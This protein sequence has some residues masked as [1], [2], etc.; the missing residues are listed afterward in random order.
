MGKLSV[1]GCVQGQRMQSAMM[2]CTKCFCPP[3]DNSSSAGQSFLG[4]TSFS[5]GDLLRT[6]EPPVSLSL[7]TLDG[8]NEAGELKVSRLQMEGETSADH[9]SAALCERLHGSFH[10]R[11]NS[12]MMRA[13]LCAQVCKVYR[14]QTEDQRWLLVR[15]Q[16]SETP[17]SFSFPKQ[18]LSALIRCHLDRVQEVKELGDLSPRWDDLRR[19]VVG[20]C[21]LL[22]GCYQ[23]TLSELHKLSASS[24]FK[25]SGSKADKQL[26]FVPTNLHAQRMEVTGPDSTG[27]WYEVITFGAPADHHQAFKHGGL[28]KL[29]S[30]HTAP[31]VSYSRDESGRARALLGRVAALQPLLF[32]LA[33]QLLAVALQRSAARLQGALQELREQTQLFV[34]ALKD[35]L[36]KSALLEIHG[37][38][39]SN[40]NG[41]GLGCDD[42]P[43]NQDE[44]QGEE[45]DEEEWDR[46]WVN[47][48]MSLNCIVA[49]VD[50]LQGREDHPQEV[51][52]SGLEVTSS[53][54][55]VTSSGLEVTS[56][57][58]EETNG[59]SSPRPP[60]SS[61]SPSSSS[62]SSSSPSWQ[63]Q[64]LPL[65]V[66]L[67]DC[68]REAADK[69]R[70]AM[71]FVVLQGAAASTVGRGPAHLVQRRHAVFSQALCAVVCGFLLKLSGRLVEDPDF[72]LQLLSVGLLVQFEGL[73]STYGDEVG[74]L[75][76][77]DVGVADL[78]SVS[79]SVTEATGERPE[80]LLPTL[81]GAWGR[82][83]VEVPLPSETFGPLPQEVRAGGLI[84]VH[85]VLF[86]VGINQQQ[87]LAERF[88]DSSLQEAVNQRGAERLRAYCGALS[89]A[90]P[91]AAALQ[92][93][94]PLLTA[95]ERR[96][97][98]RKRK[99]VS[100]L[101]SAATVC[102]E[103]NGVRLTSCKSAKDRTAMSVTLEQCVLL[104]ER[105]T[106]DPQHF[107]LA[108]D[109]MR[110]TRQLFRGTFSLCWFWRPL[111][112]TEGRLQ[113][114]QRAEECGQQEVRL[115]R[116]SAAHVPQTVPSSRRE[117]RMN[118][119]DSL[120]R[121]FF[122]IRRLDCFIT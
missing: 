54:L 21:E 40:G 89:A 10:D 115:Q 100:V 26:Q 76:D 17:L 82:W 122:S 65:V 44:P 111:W 83:V 30:K 64:L 101:W 48:A 55:E 78:S 107:S 85:P 42:T 39:N 19:D 4:F 81:T 35:E 108:L 96:L 49:M 31:S 59:D 18:L 41:N 34:H 36:V 120:Y 116:R 61:S 98:A 37:N 93:L 113:D 57:D 118:A 73:L 63:E 24:C 114:G 94:P 106:L 3:G 58:Q 88:G 7:R 13:A 51:T 68:V 25:S 1:Q 95:L 87:S 104:R 62:P 69:A 56:S 20:H 6:K 22:I 117:L 72:L 121:C 23:E 12:P 28:K 33:E 5:I 43:T 74:M 84:P 15:E 79:F 86:N 97:R 2:S 38:G 110:R 11:E 66:T 99:N 103:V 70:A 119:C 29:L 32:G 75:E 60:A 45:Y 53:G 16:M 77:M 50:R 102:R 92:A 105:H 71:T 90:R 27:V 8:V 112:T 9:K 46:A 91:Q 80:D 14:F 109:C 52:S 47:V 67:R